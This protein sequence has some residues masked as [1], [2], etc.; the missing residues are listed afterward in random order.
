[1]DA[2]EEDEEGYGPSVQD[3]DLPEWAKRTSFAENSL[4]RA[5]ALLI[6]LLPTNLLALLP[7]ELDRT[8]LLLTLSS[9]QALCVAYNVGVRRSRKPWGY[10]S[11]EAIHDILAL[12]QA[13]SASGENEDKGR[14]GWTFRR[15]DN[16][17]LWAAALKL[18][19]LIPIV[20]PSPPLGS[21][22][23]PSSSDSTPMTSPLPSTV[24]FPNTEPQVYFDARTVAR[25]DEGWE[26][27]L[28]QILERWVQAVV[29]ERRAQH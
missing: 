12:E 2:V 6:A 5:H 18:R 23:K 17:R 11:K 28:E 22:I 7:R 19:Y 10:I 26:E 1:M 9:G 20:A 21:T 14:K 4:S 13:Q 25:R 24:K 3:E 15:S 16:L 27:M 8:E 29:D